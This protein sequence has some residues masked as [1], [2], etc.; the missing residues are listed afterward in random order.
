MI[1]P[2]APLDPFTESIETPVLADPRKKNG[3]VLEINGLLYDLEVD[4]GQYHDC[5]SYKAQR[6]IALKKFWA[7]TAVIFKNDSTG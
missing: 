6:V 1:Q 5:V 7:S 2:S 3:L 4:D